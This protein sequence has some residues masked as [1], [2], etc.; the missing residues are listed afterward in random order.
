MYRPVFRITPYLLSL[1]TD[2][3]ELRAWIA[4]SVID[5]PWLPS[6][7]RDTAARLSHSST[8]IEGNPLSL[9]IVQA[10]ARGEETGAPLKAKLEVEN[11]LAA[12]QGIWRGPV[13]SSFTEKGL[14]KLHARLMKGLL[15]EEKIGR[16]K[17]RP[18]RIIDPRGRTVYIP[19]G[20]E[21]ARPETRALIA[22]LNS[23]E[24]I[25]LH[26]ILA[27]GIAHHRLVSIHPFADGNG[28]SSRAL[29]SWTLYRRRFDTHH[30]LAV[31]EF[32]EQDLRRY[33]EK[34]QQAHDLD[35][36]LTYWLEYAA[37]AVLETLRRTRSR[38]ESLPIPGAG[39]H[40]IILTAKQEE[41]LRFLRDR[42][43]VRSPDIEKA[44]R[45]TRSRVSQLMQPLV[46][47][48]LVVR[49]GQTRSTT[50]A[51]AATS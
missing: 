25:A 23:K 26:P 32:Y 19:P 28:R 2:A 41:L 49:Q 6:L 1:I 33:Y 39:P 34:I 46:E 24:A 48:R 5:V 4:R 22:W 3:T 17:S 42:G 13:K 21:S 7:Q 16:Y 47:A 20:P 18:N 35:D 30:L 27:S 50:Y 45:V 43:R 14:L 11:Y 51:L 31:D 29:A 37:E 9:P 38:I 40:K 10:I 44:L 36:D 15:P 8:S 12:L